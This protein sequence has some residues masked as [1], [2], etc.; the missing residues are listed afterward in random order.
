MVDELVL[1]GTAEFRAVG[2]EGVLAAAG[3]VR[4]AGEA[5]VDGGTVVEVGVELGDLWTPSSRISASAESTWALRRARWW[6][7]GIWA[8]VHQARVVRST[9]GAGRLLAYGSSGSWGGA[10][11]AGAVSGRPW[12]VSWVVTSEIR[13]GT[14]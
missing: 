3:A 14:G 7:L 11:V 2:E 1:R 13:W 4:A 10:G 8:A 6:V 9:G 12:L 5:V